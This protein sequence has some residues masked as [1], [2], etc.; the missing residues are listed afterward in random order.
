MSVS[1]V[2]SD[3]RVFSK[4]IT[5]VD[6]HWGECFDVIEAVLNSVD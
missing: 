4:G 5:G 2:G 3:A 1:S 6:L